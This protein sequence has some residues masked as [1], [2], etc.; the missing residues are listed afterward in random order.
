MGRLAKQQLLGRVVRA[1]EE[2]GRSVLIEEARHPFVLRIQANEG[3]VRVRVYVWNVTHGGGA[4][5]SADEYRVQVTGVSRL[6]TSGVSRT[7]VLGW[8]EDGEVFAAW[9]ALKHRGQL[10]ASPSLQVNQDC[11]RRASLD[12]VSS[13]EKGNR[14]IVVAFAPAF[15]ATYLELQNE[16]H[17]LGSSRRDLKL[18][19][20]IVAATKPATIGLG[21]ASS[22]SRKRVLSQVARTLRDSS[23]AARVLAVYGSRC[24]MCGLQLRLLDAAHIVPA[25]VSGNDS[26]SNGLALCALHHRAY[27]RSLV[28][29]DE[30]YRIVKNPDR[31]KALRNENLAG[32]LKTFLRGLRAIIVMPP[33]EADRPDPLLVKEGNRLRGWKSFER[34]A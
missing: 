15:L 4:A 22:E 9:D 31:L 34:V 8:W 1:I 23:F 2:G 17:G 3:F 7:L 5:R 14:E 25:S 21:T 20:R 32:G 29:V 11:L 12:Q 16:L 13:Q 33:D 19:H 6:D 18:F 24:A 28:S 27:D 30:K 26:T 10:G